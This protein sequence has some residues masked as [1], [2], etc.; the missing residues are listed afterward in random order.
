MAPALAVTVTLYWPTG[1]PGIVWEDEPLPP[2]A[3]N[4]MI[5]RSMMAME[6]DVIRFRSCVPSQAIARSNNEP[7]SG[8]VADGR[9]RWNQAPEVIEAAVPTLTL[10]DCVAEPLICAEAGALQAGAGLTDGVM[11]QLK[12][13]VPVNAPEG[14]RSRLKSALWPAATV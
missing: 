11:A 4:G 6:R 3:D 12:T 14:A 1:V 13:T 7:S 8:M 9:P 10:I 2:Q 5:A